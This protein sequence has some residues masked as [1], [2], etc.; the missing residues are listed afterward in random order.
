M[1][2]YRG[3]TKELPYVHN[4]TAVYI[5]IHIYKIY[6]GLTPIFR[7]LYNYKRRILIFIPKIILNVFP[8]KLEIG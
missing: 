7:L 4:Y 6:D 8:R 3:L 5:H 1:L 2:A